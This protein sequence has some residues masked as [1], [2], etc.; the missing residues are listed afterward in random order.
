[1]ASRLEDFRRLGV[2]VVA[3]SMSRPDVLARYLADHPT[4]VPLFADPERK[5][6]ADLGLQRTTWGRLLRPGLVWRY[7]KLIVRGGK[8]RRVPE[9]EDALQLGGDF[10]IGADRQVLWEYR[11]ADPADRPSAADLF[12]VART[13]IDG[14][15]NPG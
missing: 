2:G 14:H 13:K 7:L 6:Y 15:P 4:P 1:V 9:G 11:S 3:V 12:Q 8:L 10:L 5:L